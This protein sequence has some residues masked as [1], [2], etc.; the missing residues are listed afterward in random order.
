MNFMVLVWLA[1]VIGFLIVELITPQLVSIWFAGGSLV[2][3]VLAA[4]KIH[5]GW[6]VVC[7]L[8]VSV[9]LLAVTRPLYHKLISKRITPTNADALIGQ[10]AL[11][12][13]AIDPATYSGLV[14]VRGQ[15]WSAK[16]QGGSAIAAGQ[17]VVIQ[18]IEGVHL[19]VAPDS[20]QKMEV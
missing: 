19:V 16:S 9:V 12:T 5:W 6:Q 13:A 10:Q 8:L 20:A 2:G 7:F 3:L 1:A 18:A 17:T 11:V 14:R 15:V 4:L